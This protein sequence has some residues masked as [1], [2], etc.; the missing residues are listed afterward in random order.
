[1]AAS[2]TYHTQEGSRVGL[3]KAIL[4]NVPRETIIELVDPKSKFNEVEPRTLLAVI[5]RDADP[6]T[7][8]EAK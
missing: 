8:V 2:E 3:R 4:A 5:L 1:M 7:V 6:A